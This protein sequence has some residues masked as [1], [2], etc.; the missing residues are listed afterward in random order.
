MGWRAVSCATRCLGFCG[1]LPM[2][3]RSPLD[4]IES[5]CLP[6]RTAAHILAEI[7]GAELCHV[8]IKEHGLDPNARMGPEAEVTTKG[9]F[10]AGKRRLY[11]EAFPS[12]VSPVHTAVSPMYRSGEPA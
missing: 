5:V 6:I 9:K 4:L 11:V 12:A 1:S 10:A 7:G 8:L 3:R 2:T